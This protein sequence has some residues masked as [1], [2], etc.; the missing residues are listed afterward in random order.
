MERCP[1]CTIKWREKKKVGILIK[2]TCLYS[3][4]N[5]KRKNKKILPGINGKDLREEKDV[6]H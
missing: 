3:D 1:R 6:L 2:C 5:K 4:M